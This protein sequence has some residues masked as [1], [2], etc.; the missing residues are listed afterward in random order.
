MATN[1]VLSHFSLF[2]V[3]VSCSPVVFASL[4]SFYRSLTAKPE[5]RAKQKQKQ[6]SERR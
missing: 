6:K 3:R 5:S 1:E 2:M 4:S